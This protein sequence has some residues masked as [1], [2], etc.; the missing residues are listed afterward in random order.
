[1]RIRISDEIEIALE[2]NARDLSPEEKKRQRTRQWIQLQAD[3]TVAGGVATGLVSVSDGKKK[4]LKISDATKKETGDDA[5]PC[6]PRELIASA[7]LQV[8]VP[9]AAF[10]PPFPSNKPYRSYLANM[11]VAPEA[12][13]SGV[14]SKVIQYAERLT[15]LWGFTEMWLHVNID[16]GGAFAL[17]KKL[18]Y[19]IVSTDPLWYLDRRYLMVKK[20]K[21]VE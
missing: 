10:P 1:M 15:K 9:D 8:C 18:G 3:G 5:R 21:G 14:A 20:L 6:E 7:T 11:A 19:E 2:E 17:Y 12:R 4:F 16:N 13:R